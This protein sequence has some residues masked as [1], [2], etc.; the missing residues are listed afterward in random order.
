[1]NNNEIL[2]NINSLIQ[3]AEKEYSKYK[4]DGNPVIHMRDFLEG[5]IEAFNECKKILEGMKE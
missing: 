3:K 1:M 5:K 4:S 2:E